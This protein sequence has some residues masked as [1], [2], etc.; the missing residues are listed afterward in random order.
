MAEVILRCPFCAEPLPSKATRCH[1][2]GRNLSDWEPGASSLFAYKCYNCR[3][4]Q[5]ADITKC[6]NC[7]APKL[8]QDV[9]LGHARVSPS[10]AGVSEETEYLADRITGLA[11]LHRSYIETR[12]KSKRKA[13]LLALLLPGTANLYVRQYLV[14][15]LVLLVDLLLCVPLMFSG[16]GFIYHAVLAAIALAGALYEIDRHNAALERHDQ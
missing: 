5:P 13:I 4:L 2:C 1:T 16:I 12:R 6:S 7:G 9:A 14:G 8:L 15:T 3:S 10:E 11:R